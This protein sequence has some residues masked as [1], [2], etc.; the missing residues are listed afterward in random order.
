[1]TA[2]T[3]NPTQKLIADLQTRAIRKENEEL[4]RMLIRKE[5]ALQGALTETAV[6]QNDLKLVGSLMKQLEQQRVAKDALRAYLQEQIRLLKIN[7]FANKNED[8]SEEIAEIEQLL[9]R[10]Q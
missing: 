5:A 10:N 3:E 4:K 8:H 9:E 7:D 2:T 6:A 1:M